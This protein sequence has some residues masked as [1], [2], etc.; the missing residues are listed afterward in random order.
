MKKIKKISIISFLFCLTILSQDS[1]SGD[2]NPTVVGWQAQSRWGAV[3]S[4]K[5][6]NLLPSTTANP[7]SWVT[8]NAIVFPMYASGNGGSTIRANT[9]WAG[10]VT[11][12]EGESE[13]SLSDAFSAQ[14]S[15]RVEK[16][17]VNSKLV[18]L[19]PPNPIDLIT[20]GGSL[21]AAKIAAF[22]GGYDYVIVDLAGQGFCGVSLSALA[23]EGLMK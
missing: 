19:S 16:L 8:A 20:T 11:N 4:I 7:W 5:L 22:G 18:K 10:K 21:D 6:Q 1:F 9:L 15:T 23:Y 3:S 2:P 14:K 12:V 13:T 17:Y